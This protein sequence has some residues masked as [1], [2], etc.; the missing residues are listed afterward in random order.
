MRKLK[1]LPTFQSIL[2]L[3]SALTME[4]ACSGGASLKG[5][6]G[7]GPTTDGGQDTGP[8]TALADAEGDAGHSP[9]P[10]D[11]R[12]DTA[13]ADAGNAP[14]PSDARHDSD[15][16]DA[17][18]ATA[19]TDMR[20]DPTLVESGDGPTPTDASHS[21][22]ST[23][24]GD[25]PAKPARL[26]DWSLTPEGAPALSLGTWKWDTREKVHCHFVTAEDDQVRCLPDAPKYLINNTVSVF[27]DS[28][29]QQGT[30]GVQQ[31]GT[32]PIRRP[33][34][35]AVSTVAPCGPTR[36]QV[37]RPLPEGTP[38]YLMDTTSCK[39]YKPAAGEI[40]VVP[41]MPDPPDRWELGTPSDGARVSDRLRVAEIATADGARFVDHLV[42]ERWAM[43]CGLST[44]KYAGNLECVPPKAVR[45]PQPTFTDTGCLTPVY[46]AAVGACEPAPAFIDDGNGARF[47]VGPIYPGSIFRP[48]L[49]PCELVATGGYALDENRLF[50]LGTQ[51]ASDAIAQVA[52]ATAGTGRFR[53][54]G[55]AGPG[56]SVVP[57]RADLYAYSRRAYFDSVANEDCQPAWSPDG[58]ARCVP[59][60]VPIVSLRYFSDSTCTRLIFNCT[61]GTAC[62]TQKVVFGR[63]DAYGRIQV[64]DGSKAA[65]ALA[66]TNIYYNDGTS[67][68][69]IGANV[70]GQYQSTGVLP[71]DT[72]PELPERNP[73]PAGL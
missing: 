71:W 15:P 52:E 11:A 70:E 8:P 33:W 42:D 19:P 17:A 22:A 49:L 27:T 9:A 48:N 60:S 24:A 32:V 25:G 14:A 37:L 47:T 68:R 51:L 59:E 5:S 7:Q 62:E 65:T 64:T 44:V 45:L 69:Q 12:K 35:Y 26:E 23:D 30:W 72:F 34:A 66:K 50:V 13:P 36:Y 41:L 38:L 10:A 57:I 29:C 28:K 58:K 31:D 39:P 1:D 21:P 61:G 6:I 40:Q 53:L 56:N 46:V 18:I 16:A 55:L 43:A 20:N 3:A 63:P 73:L 4:I 54:R 67:C 2:L